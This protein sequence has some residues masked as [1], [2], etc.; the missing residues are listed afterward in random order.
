MMGMER[1]GSRPDQLFSLFRQTLPGRAGLSIQLGKERVPHD[2][3]APMI[4]D[5]ESNVWLGTWTSGLLKLADRNVTMIPHRSSTGDL[6][7]VSAVSDSAGHIWVSG[8]GGITE[9]FADSADVWHQEFHRISGLRTKEGFY[10]SIVDRFG[11]IWCVTADAREIRGFSVKPRTDRP[12]VLRPTIVLRR[13][14]DFPEGVLLTLFVDDRDRMFISIGKAGVAIVDLDSGKPVGLMTLADSI[15]G[16]DVRSVLQDHHGNIWMG[17]WNDGIS[18]FTSGVPHPKLLRTYRT[19]DGLPD[20]SIRAL[21]EDRTGVMW[22]GTRHGGLARLVGDR[23]R[24]TSMADGLLSNS[25]WGIQ[26]DGSDHLY[27]LTDAGIE[28]VSR[29]NAMPLFQKSELRVPQGGSMGQI[30]GRY[31]WH[32]S[33]AGLTVFDHARSAGRQPGPAVHLLSC[34]VSGRDPSDRSGS[35]IS[36]YTEHVHHRVHRDQLQRRKGRPISVSADRR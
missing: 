6:N 16:A 2:V 14:K 7:V 15:P 3:V 18:V 21:H 23:F 28:R 24:T 12:S 26:E 30:H 34:T 10:T 22:V 4:L 19:E 29:E 5:R 13:G 36:P 27:L 9:F 33:A 8:K 11:K 32:A 1:S 25:V 31:I 17:G 20:N 35:G